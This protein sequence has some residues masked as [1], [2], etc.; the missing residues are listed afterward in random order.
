[1]SS[2][3]LAPFRANLENRNRWDT[4]INGPICFLLLISPILFA[5]YDWGGEDQFYIAA[6][7]EYAAPVVASAVEAFMIVVLLFTMYNRFVTH[8]KRDR[9]WREALIH[10]AESQGLGIQGLKAEHQAITDKDTFNMVRPLMAVIA[11]TAT[12]SFLAI[13]FFPMDLTG[14]FL[15]WI[16][17]LLGLIIAIP[18]CVRYPLR[19]ESD[20]IRFTEVLAET[21]RSTGE[22]IMPM[23]K[24]VK[25]TKLWIHVALLLI[26]SGLYAVIW[27]VMMVRAMNRHLRYQHSYEDHLLQFLEGDKNAFEGALDEEGKV[28][29]KRHMPKNL[30]ITELLL[31]AIC[32]TYMTRITGIVTDFNMGMV[33][34][35]IIN[36]INIEEYYNYGMILLYLALMMLAMRALIGIASGRLQSWRRV[37]RSCIA[38]VIPILASMYIYN[39]GSYVHLFD[40]NP[41]VT[42]AVAYGIILMTVMSVSI[43]AYYTPKGREMP[44]VREWFR[45]V[46]FGK[47][48][49]DEEDSIWEKIKSSIF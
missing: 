48:Y 17:V 29:R 49:G 8:S 4:I 36:N 2:D 7:D 39:P 20:Q 13:V 45:Y 33:G 34:N 42:L 30:F 40:L 3:S 15:I 35:T 38:F 27:L 19:H 26:T 21:F 32:F 47:L 12:G 44:K 10:H 28:I 5:F 18:T 24:V 37:I 22:E 1:M 46:F 41:Y 23:P 31:V 14:R 11:L 43:R 9:M 6:F 25:D 16:P